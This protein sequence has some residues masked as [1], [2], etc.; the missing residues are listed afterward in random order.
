MTTYTKKWEELEI[1]EIVENYIRLKQAERVRSKNSYENLKKNPERYNDRLNKN[2]VYQIN[3][4]EEQKANEEKLKQMKERRKVINKT[5][6][7]KKKQ[8]QQAI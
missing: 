1:D 4:I 2:Y 5:Y 7:Q 6:Y 3:Y 8:L